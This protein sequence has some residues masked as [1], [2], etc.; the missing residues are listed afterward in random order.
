MGCKWL[1][2][3][4]K[5]EKFQAAILEQCP[6]QNQKYIPF[7]REHGQRT[8]PFNAVDELKCKQAWVSRPQYNQSTWSPYVSCML[9]YYYFLKSSFPSSRKIESSTAITSPSRQTQLLQLCLGPCGMK[10]SS[11]GAWS[12]RQ[13]WRWHYWARRTCRWC[14]WLIPVICSGSTPRHA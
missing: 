5:G 11:T 8:W 10:Q 14:L 6:S 1:N 4:Q 3:A 2:V 7:F 12:S 9:C 13:S